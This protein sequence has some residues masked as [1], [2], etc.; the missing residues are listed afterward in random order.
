MLPRKTD[1]ILLIPYEFKDAVSRLPR[2]KPQKA[3]AQETSPTSVSFTDII[4][5]A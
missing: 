1:K 4:Q 3:R 5:A 2:M